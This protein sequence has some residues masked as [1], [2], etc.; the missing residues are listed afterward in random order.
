MSEIVTFRLDKESKNKA[1]RYKVNISRV[2][3]EALRLEIAR[4]ERE[5]LLEELR[6]MKKILK[7]IQPEEIVR[8][9]RESRDER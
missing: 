7:K 6:G 4:M 2:A 5:E 9:V 3:R 1:K 8:A